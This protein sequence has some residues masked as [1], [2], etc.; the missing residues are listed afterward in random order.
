MA[1]SSISSITRSAITGLIGEPIAHPP[2]RSKAGYKI[3]RNTGLNYLRLRITECHQ[4]IRNLQAKIQELTQNLKN[5]LSPEDMLALQ[6]VVRQ[7]SET[8]S[9]RLVETHTG[10][11]NKLI[12]KKT[13]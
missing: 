13:Q 3:A 2:I 4:S 10:K 6:S 12:G 11:I 5:H 8:I 1:I 7:L 9:E